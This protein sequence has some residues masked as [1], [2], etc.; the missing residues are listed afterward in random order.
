MS[1]YS[2]HATLYFLEDLIIINIDKLK[3]Y[4]ILRKIRNVKDFQSNNFNYVSFDLTEA[5]NKVHN[6]GNKKQESTR[7][8]RKFN[9]KEANIFRNTKKCSISY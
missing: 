2:S 5:N 4:S 1:V 3:L 8:V 9:V 7:L 6:T